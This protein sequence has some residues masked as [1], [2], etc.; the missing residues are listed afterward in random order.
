MKILYCNLHCFY[1]FLRNVCSE[2]TS[3]SDPSQN[4]TERETV[5]ESNKK[6]RQSGRQTEREA[7]RQTNRKRDSQGDKQKKIQSGRQTE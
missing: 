1:S 4:R 6:E 2:L 3:K 5:R 7:V